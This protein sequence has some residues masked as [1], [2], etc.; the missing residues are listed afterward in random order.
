MF[1]VASSASPLHTVYTLATSNSWEAT[2]GVASGLLCSYEYAVKIHWI[3]CMPIVGGSVV[4]CCAASCSSLLRSPH[5]KVR[6]CMH[7][8]II[9]RVHTIL[10]YSI[11]LDVWTCEQFCWRP[12]LE[13]TPPTQFVSLERLLSPM[14]VVQI[15]LHLNAPKRSPALDYVPSSLAGLFHSFSMRINGLNLSFLLL[16]TCQPFYLSKNGHLELWKVHL[17]PISSY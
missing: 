9:I 1:K 12:G 2:C 14:E 13:T 11:L 7:V 15:L 5:F 17:I 3:A 8:Y 6:T 4:Y 10:A 16:G